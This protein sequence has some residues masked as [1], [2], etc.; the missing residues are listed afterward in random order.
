[1][2]SLKKLNC[3]TNCEEHTL[4]ERG[5]AGSPPYGLFLSGQ[6][7]QDIPFKVAEEWVVHSVG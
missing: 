7:R 5:L 4:I 2:R 3:S 1:M 6:P